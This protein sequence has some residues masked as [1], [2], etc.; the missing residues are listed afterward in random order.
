M[1][2]TQPHV[3]SEVRD[4]FRQS[5]AQIDSTGARIALQDW[6]VLTAA[7]EAELFSGRG[8]GPLHRVSSS[9]RPLPSFL[10][11]RPLLTGWGTLRLLSSDDASGGVGEEH[12]HNAIS[13]EKRF[14]V[15][16]HDALYCFDEDILVPPSAEMHTQTSLSSEGNRFP[17]STIPLAQ[18]NVSA[19]LDR[20]PPLLDLT[21]FSG[22]PMVMLV[23]KP[24]R[25]PQ[26]PLSPWWGVTDVTYQSL[27]MLELDKQEQLQQWLEKIEEAAWESSTRELALG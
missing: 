22:D 25:N 3:Q 1:M 4:E 13:G 18:C 15:L 11:T 17:V 19:D 8:I 7:F 6:A 21:S 24:V 2:L 12:S 14:F 27:V 20:H 26:D 10:F 16:T 23:N 9:S 5:L